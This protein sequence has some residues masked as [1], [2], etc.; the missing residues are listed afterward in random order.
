MRKVCCGV[1]FLTIFFLFFFHSFL[2]VWAKGK[3][4]FLR[5]FSSFSS[6][7][8][9]SLKQFQQ[10][11]SWWIARLC[12]SREKNDFFL[13]KFIS[14]NTNTINIFTRWRMT[15]FDCKW[16]R[17]EM[18][19]SWPKKIFSLFRSQQQVKKLNFFSSFAQWITWPLWNLPLCHPFFFYFVVVVVCPHHYRHFSFS[20]ASILGEEL[21][22]R[23]IKWKKKKNTAPQRKMPI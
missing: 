8:S 11:S 10:I 5:G 17:Q 18:L 13:N 16:G 4:L 2:T 7:S 20:I 14:S 6:S 22:E 3:F 9:S 15:R 1:F 12:F 21:N 19:K 23:K